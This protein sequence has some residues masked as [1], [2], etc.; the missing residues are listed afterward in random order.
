MS[1]YPIRPEKLARCIGIVAGLIFMLRESPG[2]TIAQ[3]FLDR[4]IEVLD[5][6][7]MELS[8]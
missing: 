8:Q 2:G 5:R 1:D 3:P 6:L 4:A 7:K